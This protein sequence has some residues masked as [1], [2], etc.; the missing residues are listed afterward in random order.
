MK[1]YLFELNISDLQSSEK[2]FIWAIR[3]WLL[4]TRLAKDPKIFLIDP[5]R[6]C[7]IQ[8]SLFPLDKIMRTLACFTSSQI[9]IRCHCSEQIG[10]NEID[11]LCL[12]SINQNKVELKPNKI[13]KYLKNEHLIK[14]NKNCIK[15]IESFNRANFFFPMRKD[16]ISSYNIFNECKDSVVYFDF[17]N[18]TLQ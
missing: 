4:C 3:E 11:L 13:L 9:D 10:A 16:L 1:N 7:D 17:K 12:L 6:K 2:I 14:L 5:F 18:K 8:E 15:L